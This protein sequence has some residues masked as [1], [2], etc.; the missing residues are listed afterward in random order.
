MGRPSRHRGVVPSSDPDQPVGELPLDRPDVPVDAFWSITV[1]NA[2]GF[3]E[4]NDHSVYNV[5]SVSGIKNDDGS[6][7]VNFGDGDLPNTIG[8]EPGLVG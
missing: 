3:F 2:A 5:N 4:P 7:T 8:D 6:I 1:Y